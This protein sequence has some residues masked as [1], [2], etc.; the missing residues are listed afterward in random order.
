P[1]IDGAAFEQL[2]QLRTR[3]RYALSDSA[4]AS[5]A[6]P[7]TAPALFKDRQDKDEGP[8]AFVQR[9]YSKW[10]WKNITRADIR[11]L[12]EQLYNALYNLNDPSEKL[13][14]IGLLTKKQINDIKL[15]TLSADRPST[16]LKMAELPPDE[17][18]R[19]RLFNLSRSRKHRSKR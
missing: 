5:D 12:D 1:S 9:T 8:I 19:A 13:D 17:R 16:T 11:R 4:E 7:R 6:V 10:L 14:K 15:S 18:E 3:I 2:R